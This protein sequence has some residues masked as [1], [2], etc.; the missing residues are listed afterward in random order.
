MSSIYC[1]YISDDGSVIYS[2][3]PIMCRLFGV[4]PEMVCPMGCKPTKMLSSKKGKKL[5]SLYRK[6]VL[7]EL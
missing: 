5:L 3:R 7:E 6:L 2:D 4:V 1:L